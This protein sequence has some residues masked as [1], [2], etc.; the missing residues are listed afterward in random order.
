M[1]GKKEVDY[2]SPDHLNAFL[3]QI[4][5]EIGAIIAEGAEEIEEIYGT[6]NPTVELILEKLYGESPGPIE[7]AFAIKLLLVDVYHWHILSLPLLTYNIGVLRAS[8]SDPT[9]VKDIPLELGTFT[10]NVKSLSD[11]NKYLLR[12]ELGK[13]AV[14]RK[15]WDP[16]RAVITQKAL[17]EAR[18]RWLEW[19][20][21][22]GRKIHH[23]KM[24]NILFDE[25]P[26]LKEA[27]VPQKT[28]LDE[29]RSLAREIDPTLV[30]GDRIKK[31]KNLVPK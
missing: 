29:L 24:R 12:K 5:A 14:T 10:T 9:D 21:K 31:Q 7:K 3:R 17:P 13:E 20:Q 15:R 2:K 30:F 27:K 18:R 11:E 16:V 22:G 26:E 19:K 1:E 6:P 23:N 4:N 8:L 25:I 28:L